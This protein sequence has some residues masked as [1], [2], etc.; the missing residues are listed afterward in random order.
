MKLVRVDWNVPE[1]GGVRYRY[2]GE[3]WVNVPNGVR[4]TISEQSE[5]IQTARKQFI[6]Y[7]NGFG[8]STI[9]ISNFSIAA[10]DNIPLQNEVY[11]ILAKFDDCGT[12]GNFNCPCRSN[13]ICEQLVPLSTP[14]ATN[15][16]LVSGTCQNTTLPNSW[17][18]IILEWRWRS[19][20]QCIFKVFDVNNQVI[21]Q[22]S[23]DVCPTAEVYQ[24]Q[25]GKNIGSF[26]VKTNNNVTVNQ[27]PVVNNIR[28]IVV[29]DG[30]T[31]VKKFDSP[32]GCNLYPKI[33]LDFEEDKCPPN[34]CECDCGTHICCFNS[35]G[36]A[37][38]VISK[39]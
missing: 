7:P 4:F 9:K 1:P 28:S 23:R 18:D 8:G 5:Q 34:T 31:A 6:N 14:I 13:R 21:Y 11:L 35:S 36:V 16:L 37:I 22:E 17:V 20:L 26:N 27:M 32:G 38:K 12:I 3:D 30:P 15:T 2:S 25:Y 10:P 19:N 33:E 39:L 24:C 29:L